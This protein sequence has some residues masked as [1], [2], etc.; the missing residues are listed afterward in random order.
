MIEL[1]FSDKL[2]KQL[3]LN[4]YWQK[5][6]LIIRNAFDPAFFQLSAEDL[7]GLSCEPEIESRII[8]QDS[9]GNWNIQYGPFDSS[10]F[11]TLP[12]HD[13]TLLVQ[14]VDKFL[15]EVAELIQ[16]FNFIPR[17]RIDDIM[18]SYAADH[19]SVGPHTDAYDV[20][21]IQAEGIREWQLDLGNHVNTARIPDCELDLLAQF[22][23]G[24]TY[25]LT[26]G[27]LLYLPPNIAHWG[28]AQGEC[29]TWSVGFR[30]PSHQEMLFSWTEF[31]HGQ[32]QANARYQDDS[33]AL[34]DNPTEIAEQS[35]AQVMK[36]LDSFPKPTP[37]AVKHWFGCLITEIKTHQEIERPADQLDKAGLKAKLSQDSS[38]VWHPFARY[39]IARININMICLFI[40]GE[41]F[42]LPSKN[43]DFLNELSTNTHIDLAFFEKFQ[44]Q[45]RPIQLLV[46]LINY[47]YLIEE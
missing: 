38:F 14:D 6:P 22:Q 25:Q 31:T 8:D 12:D 42:S 1:N 19:G 21:L 11:A 29:I 18:I 15:P 13:W 5:K 33:L 45:A 9:D 10:T 47:G 24:E 20:F 17:W 28:I 4:E 30:A 26:P 32:L 36:I 40:C 39:A 44:Q 7:A 41:A 3:F 23:S 43:W 16:A 46:Q 35:F 27:D 37:E 34:Q 2:D